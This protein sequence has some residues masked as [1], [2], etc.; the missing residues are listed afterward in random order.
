MNK[1]I[2]RNSKKIIYIAGT[3]AALVMLAFTRFVF[4]FIADLYVKPCPEFTEFG[5]CKLQYGLSASVMGTASVIVWVMIALTI[6]IVGIYKL[7]KLI[8]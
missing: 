5:V 8:K 6:L 1:D 7:K 3:V 2:K 4:T